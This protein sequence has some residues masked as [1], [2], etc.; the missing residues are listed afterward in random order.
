M[1]SGRNRRALTTLAA[2]LLLVGPVWKAT[3]Q[4]AADLALL[5]QKFPGQPFVGITENLDVGFDLA[6]GAP[7]IHLARYKEIA[8]LAD[9]STSFSESREYFSNHYQVKKLEAYS[10]VPDQNQYRKV[11]VQSFTKSVDWDNMVYYDDQFTYTYAFPSVGKGC[12]LVTRYEATCSYPWLPVVFNFGGTLPMEKSTVS[13]SFPKEVD[14]RY[15]VFGT[16]T[17]LVHFTKAA[18]GNRMK[19]TWEAS[20]GNPFDHDA[21]APSMRYYVP[22]VIIQIAG[23]TVNGRYTPV[24]GSLD[25]L[26]RYNYSHISGLS[27]IPAPGVKRLADSL[28]AGVSDDREKVRN[29]F[30]W[31][32]KNIKYVAIEDG[33]NGLVP[34]EAADVLKRRYGDCKDKTS[35]LVAMIRSQQLNAAYAWIGSRDLPYK[36]SEFPSTMADDHMIAVWWEHSGSPVILD[37]T[38]FSHSM[39]DVPAFIQGKE[40]LIEKGPDDYLLYTI[41]VAA[42]NRNQI[43]DSL[44]IELRG[45]TVT[46][47]GFAR[48][49]GEPRADMIGRFEGKDTTAWKNILRE[50]LNRI[51][52]KI[53][54][55][56]IH[57]LGD[58]GADAPFIL[59]Y[60]FVIPDYLVKTNKSS[61][62]NLNLSRYLQQT[63]IKDDR[64]IP[65]EAEMT[66]GYRFVCAFRVPDGYSVL[67]LPRGSSYEDPSF[68]FRETYT[69]Q[70]EL[71][72]LKSDVVIN[73]LVIDGKELTAY[74]QMLSLLNRNYAKSLQ[75]EKTEI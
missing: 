69:R 60:R 6:G 4:P 9:H 43:Y 10:L 38:T 55:T 24:I 73:F 49:T 68:G 39:A 29:I 33:D 74:Q 41:P 62:I 59:E 11:P 46:G 57:V 75:L 61:Y 34:R 26:Y 19:Y 53:T 27:K 72:V 63:R 48:F 54:I 18:K 51:S 44:F 22:H 32:Q 65:V 1:I 42:V 15:H 64:K 45:D 8:V 23:Y 2:A 71:V 12:R 36:Y 67:Q 13:V 16:D 40:C 47:H 30:R 17:A 35:L 37:G 31:V 14:I 3:A 50:E 25:D 56:R 58:D 28:N 66:H 21:V 52:N 70:N 20:F 7:V 5:Q